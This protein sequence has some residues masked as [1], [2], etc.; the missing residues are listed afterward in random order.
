MPIVT[1]NQFRLWLKNTANMKLS[2]DAS[3]LRITYKG[4]KNFQSFMDFNHDSIESLS[5]SCIKN[6]D[7]IVADFPNGIAYENAVPETNISTISIR[8]LV[9]ATD[10][11]KHYTT[12]R[13]TPDFDN[14]HYVNVLGEFKTA[15]DAYVLL[16]KKTLL[17]FP[18]SVISTKR[19]K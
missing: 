14:M 9:V 4:L 16:K 11:V 15:Y 3:V 19:R 1:N 5:K 8:C 10:A 7:T 18:L 17:K 13:Q 12:N 6:I 2:Y